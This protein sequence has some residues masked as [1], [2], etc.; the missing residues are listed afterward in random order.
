MAPIAGN[1]TLGATLGEGS[2]GKV[3]CARSNAD[4][5]QHY[6][7][8]IVSK[9]KVHNKPRGAEALMK[10]VDMQTAL[11]HRHV[12]RLFESFEDPKYYYFVLELARGGDLFD[13][14]MRQQQMRFS[15]TR[16]WHYFRQ[17]VD[18]LGFCHSRGIVHRDLKPENILLDDTGAV[19]L[20]DFGLAAW[21]L[22][23]EGT[24]TALTT[25]CG[26]Q[27]YAAPELLCARHQRGYH[28]PSIDVWSLAVIHYVMLCGEFPWTEASKR[29]A[30]GQYPL[31]QSGTFEW[32]PLLG[33]ATH[34]PVGSNPPL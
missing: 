32:K 18:A 6:A 33:A 23:N 21:W 22:S 29:D 12:V 14:L 5:S 17:I 4:P 1:Y 16:A 24:C 10:E 3:K 31:L 15:P 20:S 30:A 13:E 25:P 19:K 11:N 8:K 34:R 7:I 28:G 9:A 26:T 2:F 27:Q